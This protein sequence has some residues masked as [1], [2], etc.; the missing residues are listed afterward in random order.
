MFKVIDTSNFDLE[1]VADVLIEDGFATRNEAQKCADLQ[2]MGRDENAYMWA[3][4]VDQNYRLSRGM[5]DLV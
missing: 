1:T 4:V 3:M 2:N 5:E